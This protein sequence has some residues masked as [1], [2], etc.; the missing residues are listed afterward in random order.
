MNKILRRG[1][2]TLSGALLLGAVQS[3]AQN[4][5]PIYGISPGPHIFVEVHNVLLAGSGS[6]APTISFDLY[7]SA[8]TDYVNYITANG[9]SFG[10][11]NVDV[12]FDIDLGSDGTSTTAN[13]PLVTSVVPV[14]TS[15]MLSSAS[16]TNSL[17]GGNPVGFESK[18]KFNLVRLNG[19]SAALSATPTKV[20]SAVVTLPANTMLGTVSPGGATIRL[21]SSALAPITGTSATGTAASN[22]AGVGL[23]GS[24]W[25]DFNGNTQ[26]TI[27]PS[28]NATGSQPL[29]VEL[30]EFTAVKASDN[31]RVQLDWKS[32]TETGADYYEVE[33]SATEGGDYTSIGVRVKAQGT[34]SAEHSYQSYDR[35]PLAGANWYR[36]RVVDLGGKWGYSD[37]RMV[38]FEGG[39]RGVGESV[40]FYPN[41][42][43][44]VNG[45]ATGLRVTV[46]ADQSLSYTISDGSGKLVGGG[47][48][49]VLKGESS[50]GIEGFEGLSAGTYYVSVKG[51]TLNATLKVAKSE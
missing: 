51:A 8:S 42:V 2:L 39:V 3:A 35:S 50:T 17:A 47:T 1:I 5:S 6:A 10:L 12:G 36:L 45:G 32:A 11:Q 49:E 28:A 13:P 29:A 38:R 22:I 14:V 31:E 16:G 37:K 26:N 40:S 18:F 34:S 21:R 44:R 27:G 25:S 19:V 46:S 7:L 23:A 30:M 33:R 20:I 48:I 24:K 15:T 43:T 4:T 41:P 9:S